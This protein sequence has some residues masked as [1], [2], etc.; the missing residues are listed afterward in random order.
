ME[1]D[2]K[3][4]HSL[5]PIFWGSPAIFGK[6]CHVLQGLDLGSNPKP[7]TDLLGDLEPDTCH[8]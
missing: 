6:P 2:R 8:L 4:G 5:N 7:T 3:E 1:P